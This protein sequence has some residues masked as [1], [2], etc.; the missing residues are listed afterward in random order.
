M[1]SLYNLAMPPFSFAA[2]PAFDRIGKRYGRLTVI[3]RSGS[4]KH[5][6]ATWECKCDCGNTV[7]V[8]TPKLYC[9]DRKSCGCI[10]P[11][12]RTIPYMQARLLRSVTKTESGCWEWNYSKDKAGYGSTTAYGKSVRAHRLAMHVFSGFDLTHPL[13]VCHHCDNPPC[14][15]PEHLFIGTMAENLADCFAKGRGKRGDAQ[16]D[17]TH[18]PKGHEYTEENTRRDA[19]N[20]RWC[21]TCQQDRTAR[22]TAAGEFSTG[23]GPARGERNSQAKLTEEKVAAIRANY[24]PGYGGYG[25][26]KLAQD[27][28]VS[29]PTIQR[30]LRGQ[31]WRLPSEVQ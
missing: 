18:C 25:C 11:E 15:N 7:V 17:K 28:G 24:V 9:G 29:K 5:K 19:K 16:R 27:F 6:S 21:R 13:Q 31:T 22:R 2:R 20:H 3:A 12:T 4:N 30:V 23:R 14:I 26:R 8:S 10:F 1:D